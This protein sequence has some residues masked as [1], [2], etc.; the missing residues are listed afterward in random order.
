MRAT[1]F[2]ADWHPYTFNAGPSQTGLKPSVI[3][4]TQE[5]LVLQY[6]WNHVSWACGHQTSIGCEEATQAV[7]LYCVSTPASHDANSKLAGRQ[8]VACDQ[9]RPTTWPRICL[10][11]TT[12]YSIKLL[13][14]SWLPN[15]YVLWIPLTLAVPEI[16]PI[17][18]TAP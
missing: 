2:T 17:S 5:C 14:R 8:H 4:I 16:R 13:Q 6:Q 12:F 3:V 10:Q 11:F 1:H 15:L 18:P 9:N 7:A